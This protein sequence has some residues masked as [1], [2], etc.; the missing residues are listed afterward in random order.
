MKQKWE[1]VL[2]AA[3]LAAVLGLI[4]VIILYLKDVPAS[5]NAYVEESAKSMDPMIISIG[6]WGIQDYLSGDEVLSIIEKKF[7]VK[8]KPI[9]INYTN[10]TLEYQKMAAINNLPDIIAHDI[11]GSSTYAAWV[12]QKKIRAIPSDLS[13]YPHLQEYMNLEYNQSFQEA[14]GEFY[15]IPRLTYPDEELWALDRCIVI[16]REWLEQ[17]GLK[18]PGNYEEFK[19]MLKA[20]TETDFDQNGELDTIGLA[21]ENANTLEAVYLGLYPELSNIERGWIEEDGRWIPVYASKKTGEALA[22]AKELYDLGLLDAG[23]PYRS[24]NQ[25]FSLFVDK[26]CGAIACQYFSLIQYWN[27]IEGVSDHSDDIIVMKP[28]PV[29]DGEKYRF[30]SSLHW[31][32]TYFG[33]QVSDEKM[34]KIMEIYDFLL[35]DEAEDLFY[36][37]NAGDW[38]NDNPSINALSHLVSW[39]QDKIYDKTP[40]SIK[41]YGEKNIDYAN[42]MIEWYKLNTKSVDYNYNIMFSNIQ[43]KYLLPTYNEVQNEMIQII[44]GEEDAKSAWERVMK[45]YGDE[46]SMNRI[47]NKIT[48][49][50]N[51]HTPE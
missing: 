31:S 37:G 23:F 2:K 42:E 41:I 18:L 36:G 26:K 50:V 38:I 9:N 40:Y 4:I 44:I 21:T 47:I 16:R 24:I 14:A 32:E 10:W 1:F 45:K 46:I 25:A 12:A 51:E 8:L 15:L 19:Q 17:L 29:E 7:N 49:A 48:E 3:A 33:S 6:M 30:T 27:S 28:W 43:E 39:E 35:S 13:R 34:A 11:V 5:D 22:R 20:F